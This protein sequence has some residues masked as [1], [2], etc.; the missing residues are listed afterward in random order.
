M[1]TTAW[2]GGGSSVK[3][4]LIVRQFGQRGANPLFRAV[5]RAEAVAMTVLIAVS[6]VAWLVVAILAGRWADHETRL[7]QLADRGVHPV[8]ATQL[9]SGAEA[10]TASELDMAWVPAEWK[11]PDGREGHGPIAVALNSRAG[12]RTEIFINPHGQQVR[13]PLDS[14]DVYDQVAFTVFSTTIG[15]GILFAVAYG[16]V[17]FVFNRRRMAGW[18]RDWDA[19]GPT[20]LRQD[21]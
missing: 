16:G 3:L 8:W 19:V 1:A 18:Q 17:R 5:D 7:T 4:R 11:L 6:V 21:G 15:F 14:A 20:W 10:A 2:I 13:P 12:Q 9:E